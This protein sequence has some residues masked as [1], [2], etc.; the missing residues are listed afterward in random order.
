MERKP[1]LA[2]ADRPYP[3]MSE[4]EDLIRRLYASALRRPIGERAA[5][6]AEHSGRDHDL[7]RRVDALLEGQQETELPGHSSAS[8]ALLAAGTQIGTYRIDGPLGAGGMG[9]V[10]HAT[11]T[12]LNRP[13]AIKVLPENLAD[14]EA[15]RRF[16]REAQMVSSLNHPHI[17]TVYDAGEYQDRQ[18]LITEFVD[19]GTL[20][21]WAARTRGWQQIVELLIG[22]ADGIA[23]AHEAG[24]LHRDIKP[25][26]ILLA[27][28]GYA[29]LA[30]FGLAKL[31]EVDPLAD[32]VLEAIK[33][34]DNS[35]LIGTAAYM[36]PEQAQGRT[37]DGRSDV[38]SFGLVLYELLSG[39]RPP[40]RQDKKERAL[41]PL[42]DEVPAPLRTIVAKALELEPADRY[43]TMRDL[44]VDLRRFVRRSGLDDLGQSGPFDSLIAQTGS[45]VTPKPR[46]WQR[47][48]VFII[49]L[50]LVAAVFLAVYYR[51][52]LR[53]RHSEKAVAVL[54]F[55]NETGD[56]DD[57]HISEGLGDTL[58][59]RLME[60]PGVSVQARA[61]SVSFRGQDADLRTIARSLGV[62]MLINGTL[63]RQGK[64]FEVLVEMLDEKGFAVRPAL[65]FR[66]GEQDLQALQQQIASE[67]GA[68]L[69]PAAKTALATP[70]PTPTSQSESAN[71]LVLFGNHYDHEVRDDLTVDEKKL[72]KAID[73]F[74]RATVAD[75]SSIAAHSR[76]ASALLYKGDIDEARGPLL[77]ALKLTESID[78][79][80][81]SAEVSD[82]YYTTAIYLLRTRQ[83]GVE[84]AYKKAL[85]LNPN[86]ADALGGYAL[87][88]LTHGGANVADA[89]FR[90]GIGLDRQSISRYADYGE[91]LGTV[92]EID[93]L[94][95]LATEILARFPNPRGY[96]A[97]ARLYELT[98]EIDVGIAWG[99]K[100]LQAEP[101][102]RETYWQV[103]ELFSR[104]GD[105]AEAAKYDA[106][107]AISQLWFQRRYNE[108]ID[109]AQDY[110]I[111]HP[112][113]DDAKY[114]LAFAYNAIGDYARARYLLERMGMPLP[115]GSFASGVEYQYG[116][117]YVDAL[118][119]LGGNDALATRLARQRVDN[120]T[121]GVQAGL[122]RSWW[123]NTLLACDYVQLGKPAE[124]LDSLDRAVAA[125]GLVWSPMLED[126]PCF[127]RIA[128]EPR[129]KAAVERVEE[130]KKGLRERLPA[131]LSEHGVEKRP[132]GRTALKDL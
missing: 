28:N 26:N 71:M 114:F 63:R 74:R 19:G 14:P 120:S 22:V 85:A 93:T 24:I 91:Y 32:D 53:G 56:A 117:S 110:V 131:T 3:R 48:A 124:A 118:Q 69:V 105:F 104:I 11:D 42:G 128:T 88:L 77:S 18:Y 108:L 86:N 81:A 127:K 12:K 7:R 50:V 97:L 115:L 61:S 87:W 65:T 2:D 43:Q 79:T 103:G 49:G 107:P 44:V 75:P 64:T 92:D 101:D 94:H 102:D 6:V 125:H 62:G 20:R 25:E 10:Y 29:K 121:A 45:T 109:L 99:L 96:R 82:V 130:R 34:G 113:A 31:L 59:E 17:V 1:M 9:I 16:Q 116:E 83:D 72:D 46:A 40:A 27:K 38:Y 4:R 35:T 13:A 132:P 78:P 98:G 66:R 23:V 5:F 95:E 73:F 106:D 100:A 67:V 129:Y 89:L 15:R 80:S 54:P 76:L 51:D 119:A 39:T 55:A 60:L 33:P 70:R 123:V 111:E 84:D 21:Q 112:D 36:S 122:E 37:L 41:P 58:R 47:P 30:D 126:S 57:E 68:V 90:K 8:G 52:A